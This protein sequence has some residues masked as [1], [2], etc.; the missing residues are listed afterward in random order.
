MMLSRRLA[1]GIAVRHVILIIASCI[2][3]AV[4]FVYRMGLLY[5]SLQFR[6]SPGPCMIL[7][8]RYLMN[9][10]RLRLQVAETSPDSSLDLLLFVFPF[11][12]YRPLV[13]DE[14]SLKIRINSH[15]NPSEAVAMILTH[16]LI[17]FLVPLVLLV[18][19]S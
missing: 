17:F 3:R 10:L 2:V 7:I 14:E 13:Y 12:I 15:L 16:L 8:S 11:L 6:T 9:V 5:T 1:T 4:P 19:L 18:A